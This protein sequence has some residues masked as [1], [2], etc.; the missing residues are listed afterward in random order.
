MK[1]V[2]VMFVIV[3]LGAASLVAAEERAIKD[4][5]KDVAKLALVWTEPIKQVARN[6]R[7]FDPVSGFWLGLVEGSAKSV[8]RTADVLLPDD[9]EQSPKV[10][11]GKLL[12]RYTF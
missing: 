9:K 5:P 12:Y 11:S 10:K 8:E 7:R 3:L 4:L 6:A 2:P 1:R